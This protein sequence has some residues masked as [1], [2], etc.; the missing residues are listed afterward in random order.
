[1]RKHGSTMRK[2]NKRNT[3]GFADFL[4][5]SAGGPGPPYYEETGD[6]HP[7]DLLRPPDY[8]ETRQHYEETQQEEHR[9]IC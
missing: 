8:E 6:K 3:G 2:P 4:G 9:R 1:M 7:G 5:P